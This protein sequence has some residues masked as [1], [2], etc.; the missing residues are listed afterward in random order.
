MI[1][2]EKYAATYKELSREISDLSIQIDCVP[3]IPPSLR[4]VVNDH[5]FRATYNALTRENKRRFWRSIISSITY[6]DTP[7]TRGKGAYIPFKVIFL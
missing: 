4:A 3:T 1:D 2:K 7:E 5:D 6:E